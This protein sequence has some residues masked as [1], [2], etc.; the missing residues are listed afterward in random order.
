V[1][2]INSIRVLL[3]MAKIF[4]LELQQADVDSV[5]LYGDMDTEL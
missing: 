3:S 5:F 1:A 2:K 4:G